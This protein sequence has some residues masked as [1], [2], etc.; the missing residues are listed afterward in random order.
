MKTIV[1]VLCVIAFGL[2]GNNRSPNNTVPTYRAE[3][4]AYVKRS[5][6]ALTYVTEN[7]AFRFVDVLGDQGNYEAVLLLEETYRNERTDGREG[8]QGIAAVRAWTLE[9]GRRTARWNFSEPGNT[10]SIQDRFF[11][12]TAWGCCDVPTTYLYR[13]LLTGEKVY[14]SNSDLLE[15]RGDGDGPQA[16]RYVGFGYAG[17]G[18]LSHPPILQYGT[19]RKVSQRLAV[20]SS[21]QYYDA[22]QMFVSKDDGLKKS[23]DLRGSSMNFEIILKYQD[24]V[25]LHIPTEGDTIRA[26]RAVL[27]TGYS[28]KSEAVFQPQ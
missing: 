9:H 18:E 26:E 15:V 3:S 19:D 8:V 25:E 4:S 11:R 17:M 1:A 7:R 2:Q 23:L 12:V 14:V 10:G 28:L 27:P 13:N 21:R 22:P 16:S 6:D 24:G 20:I 5:K